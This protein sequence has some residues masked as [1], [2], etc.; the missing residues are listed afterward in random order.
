MSATGCSLLDALD[1]LRAGEMDAALEPLE[2]G[3]TAVLRRARRSRRRA[4][5]GA[6]QPRPSAASAWTID[7]NCDVFSLPSRDQRRTVGAG[8]R[9]RDVDERPD[10]VVLGLVNQ[11]RARERRLGQRRQH[12]PRRCRIFAPVHELSAGRGSRVFGD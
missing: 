9:R 8:A 12:R 4:A 3:R 1:V 10:A 11:P 7:G 6:S 2:P 5:T